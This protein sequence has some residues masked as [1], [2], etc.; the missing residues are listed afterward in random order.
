MFLRR[1]EKQPTLLS[2]CRPTPHC[3]HEMALGRHEFVQNQ[4]AAS[5]KFDDLTVGYLSARDLCLIAPLS[6]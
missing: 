4:P 5:K 2:A 3:C 6:R 1:T